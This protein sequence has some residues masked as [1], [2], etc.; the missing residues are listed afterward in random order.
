MGTYRGYGPELGLRG[1]WVGLDGSICLIRSNNAGYGGV[2]N[3]DGTA[4]R[5]N[6]YAADGTLKA[7]AIINGLGHGDCGLG[8]DAAGIRGLHVGPL[9]QSVVG[10]VQARCAY[11]ELLAAAAVERSKR[12]A[13]QCLM[14]DPLTT[15]IPKAKA[16]LE[17]MFQA[18]A[19]FLPGY[20]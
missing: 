13:L 9:P 4:G 1:H 15:S 20:E 7:G 2:G 16:C 8:V 18:Q 11:Y 6:V 17:E 12:L 3:N 19:E 5:V 14:A 10:L